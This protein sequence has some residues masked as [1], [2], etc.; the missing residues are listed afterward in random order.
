MNPRSDGGGPGGQPALAQ[1]PEASM[2][3]A[4]FPAVEG[5]AGHFSWRTRPGDSSG[6]ELDL[7]VLGVFF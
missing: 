5:R 1:C 7:S 2:L 4:L 3:S 6:L